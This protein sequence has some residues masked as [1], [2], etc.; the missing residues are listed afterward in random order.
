MPAD[1][2]LA[3]DSPVGFH[4][5]NLNLLTDPHGPVRATKTSVFGETNLRGKASV[6]AG[7]YATAAEAVG[8][9]FQTGLG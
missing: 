8:S 3:L 4:E 6:A 7:Q 9:G 1:R 5:R 2:V